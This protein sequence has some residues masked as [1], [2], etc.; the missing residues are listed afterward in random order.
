MNLTESV[1][2]IAEEGVPVVER[3]YQRL[4]EELPAAR[5]FFDGVN[6]Q[7]QS[8]MLTIALL[9]VK[10]YPALSGAVRDYLHILGTKHHSMGVPRELYSP[11]I[12]LLLE[13]VAGIHG[14][15]WTE[16]LARQWSNAL[17]HAQELM[18]EGYSK[19]YQEQEL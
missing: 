17:H 7:S 4:L 9:A 1:D 15:E 10:E 16:R 3:F 14:D 18:F 6:M 19:H 5:P 12:E 2:R 8:V 13:S 11:F